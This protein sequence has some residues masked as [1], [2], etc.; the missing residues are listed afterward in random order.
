MADSIE[1]LSFGRSMPHMDSCLGI[2]LSPD[3]IYL[4]EVKVEKGRP[5]VLHLLRLP[6]PGGGGRQ[7]KTAATLSGDFLQDP[8]KV[9]AVLQ[10]ALSEGS[11]KSKNV[12]VTLSSE[13]GILRYFVM[14]AIDRRFWRS[15]VPVEAKKYIPIPFQTLA[16]DNQVFVLPPGPDRKPRL[17]ALFGVTQR[18]SLE[19]LRTMLAKLGLT[20]VGTEVAPV[21]VE[22]LWDVLAPDTAASSYA[23]VHFDG[24]HARILVSDKGVP[25]FYREAVLGDDATVMDRRKVDLVGCVDFAR[26]QL[27]LIEPRSIRVSG[28]IADMK[29]WQDAFAQDMGQPVGY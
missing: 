19:S 13:F 1:Q 11:W 27:G 4:S 26:K 24:G 17:G 18:K 23:Q 9:A 25:V 28:Q 14:P 21:S 12:M 6:M 20:L 29:A 10:K 22:R 16:S 2:F 7:T 5:Q 15:A 3:A 8:D